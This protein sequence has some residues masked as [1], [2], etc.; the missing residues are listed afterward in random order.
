M[1]NNLYNSCTFIGTALGDKT[2]EIAK[3]VATDTA[4]ELKKAAATES[5][6][7]VDGLALEW[8]ETPVAVPS[9]SPEP[10]AEVPPT[11]EPSPP[12]KVEFHMT[13]DERRMKK[14][15]GTHNFY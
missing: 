11:P 7:E 8:L 14:A 9:P 2:V 15:K 6:E 12:P 5:E 3:K 4:E 1:M 13:Q 10:L